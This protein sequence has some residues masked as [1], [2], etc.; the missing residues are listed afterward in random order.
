[1]SLCPMNLIYMTRP[2]RLSQFDC[3][4]KKTGSKEEYTSCTS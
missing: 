3:K 1:V 4:L 2:L